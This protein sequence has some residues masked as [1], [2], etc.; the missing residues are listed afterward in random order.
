MRVQAQ[1][2][3][4]QSQPQRPPNRN[5]QSRATVCMSPPRTRPT[6]PRTRGGQQRWLYWLLSML[7]PGASH[8]KAS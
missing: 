6:R 2:G 7:A 4:T 8:A 1:E 5:T 3:T